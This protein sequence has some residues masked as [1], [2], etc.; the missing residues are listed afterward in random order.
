MTDWRPTASISTLEVRASMLRAAREYFV[1]TRAVEVETPTLARAAVSD[2]HLQS[3]EARAVGQ[4][5]FL[6][7]SPEYWMKRL[8]AAGSGDL[9][10]V[11]IA[12]A[13]SAACTTP[14]SH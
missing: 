13:K 10:Q 2:I 6:P 9:W 3:I 12:M 8:L 11:C 4:R 5:R 1:A 14:S 7:T